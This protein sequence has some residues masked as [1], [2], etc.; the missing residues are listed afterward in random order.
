MQMVAVSI[1]SFHSMAPG[2]G[3]GAVRLTAAGV[4]LVWDQSL[5]CLLLMLEKKLLNG[6]R[7]HAQVAI[8]LNIV[9]ANTDRPLPLRKPADKF[10][11]IKWTV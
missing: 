4:R 3:N 5:H 2:G 10:G 7:S 9:I 6:T 8:Q 1:W 11:R